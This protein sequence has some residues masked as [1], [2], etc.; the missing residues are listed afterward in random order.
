VFAATVP[1]A[2]IATL[3][4]DKIICKTAT[5]VLFFLFRNSAASPRRNYVCGITG[6]SQ[7]GG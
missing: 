3:K 7:H 6:W 2:I 4:D 1:V 5:K